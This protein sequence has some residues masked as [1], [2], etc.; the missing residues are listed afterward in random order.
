MFNETTTE[1][2]MDNFL[3]KIISAYARGRIFKYLN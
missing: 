2:N 1:V 3:N